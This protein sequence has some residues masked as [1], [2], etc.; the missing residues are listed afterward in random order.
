MGFYMGDRGP[1]ITGPKKDENFSGVLCRLALTKAVGTKVANHCARFCIGLTIIADLVTQSS[2]GPGASVSVLSTQ[3]HPSA[4]KPVVTQSPAQ[5]TICS[6][7][8]K[9]ARLSTTYFT[10]H[11][12]G[13]VGILR[14]NQ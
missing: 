5:L 3:K 9:R 14:V 8:G 7:E 10:S 6:N 2:Q 4:V 13:R 11:M 1:G 12:R